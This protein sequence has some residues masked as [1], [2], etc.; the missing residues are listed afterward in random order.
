[1]RSEFSQNLPRFLKDSLTVKNRGF[2]GLRA[3][4]EWGGRMLARNF[5]SLFTMSA[6]GGEAPRLALQSP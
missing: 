5:N 6:R 4:P 3:V 1:M 2:P